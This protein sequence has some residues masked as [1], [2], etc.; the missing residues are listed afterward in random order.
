[1]LK[2]NVFVGAAKKIQKN[3]A[4][5][6]SRVLSMMRL[7]SRLY[8]SENLWRP[9]SSRNSLLADS[10]TFSQTAGTYKAD[11]SAQFFFFYLIQ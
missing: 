7:L 3:P 10:N 4:L 1:M 9:S 2:V 11:L 8:R 6:Y 5:D